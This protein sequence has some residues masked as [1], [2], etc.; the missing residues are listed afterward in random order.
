MRCLAL[1]QCWNTQRGKTVFAASRIPE[2]LDGR[3][4][5]EGISVTEI[6]SSPGTQEDAADLIAA[7][8]QVGAKHVVLDG[9]HFGAR[10]QQAI[11]ETDLRV[12]LIDDYGH[13]ECYFADL[14]L[15][16][17]LYADE[18]MY[19]R[20][21][22]TT[23][24]LLRTRY[25][26]L[27]REFLSWNNWSRSIPTV[28][29]RLLVTLGGSDP[30]N[31]T[32]QV[33]RSL[34]DVEVP[35]LKVKILIGLANRHHKAVRQATEQVPGRFEIL[36]SLADMAGVMAWA[37]LAITAAGTT[38]L[39]LAFMGLPSVTVELADNQRRI[40]ER[41]AEAGIS[42]NAGWHSDLDTGQLTEVIA[43]LVR[44]ADERAEM[45]RRGRAIVDGFGARRVAQI[46]MGADA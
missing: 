27:R 37:D 2:G 14:I 24:L 10:Y 25:A 20:R 29:R 45:S 17:N 5:S 28:A 23:Q 1:A 9:Y 46:L 41:L 39:E 30:Y 11:K 18:G 35:D 40:A 3:L 19:R 6:A 12:L 31:T 13:A 26:L 15:N 4:K 8:R 33:V 42:F 21:N 32:C 7:A 44:S 16:Q 36:T 34:C 22:F 43:R 38:C